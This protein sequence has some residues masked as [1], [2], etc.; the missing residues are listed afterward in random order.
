MNTSPMAWT[1][2]VM[3]P[4]SPHIEADVTVMLHVT[5]NTLEA[6]ILEAGMSRV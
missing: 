3:T 1:A 2:K 6:I 4:Y 5:Y